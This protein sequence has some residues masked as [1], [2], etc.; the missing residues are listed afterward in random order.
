MKK[1]S[2]I[3]LGIVIVVVAVIILISVSNNQEQ[4]YQGT[5]IGVLLPLSGDFA[6]FGE[7]FKRGIEDASSS[8]V[9]LIFEDTVCQNNPTISGFRKLTDVDGVKYIIGPACSSPQ[10]AIAPLVKEK[11]IL[12]ILPLAASEDLYDKSGGKIYQMQYSL[13]D[14]ASYLA[15]TLAEKGYEKVTL[16]GYQN[17]LSETHRNSFK[18]NFNGEIQEIVFADTSSNINTEL[19]KIASFEPDAIFVTDISFFVINGIEKVR[20]FNIE[21]PIFSQYATQYDPIR[22]FVEGVTYSFPGDIDINEGSEYSLAKQATELLNSLIEECSAEFTCVK[23][24]LEA[25]DLFNEKGIST[26][27][28]ILKK[29]VEGQPTEVE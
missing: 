26:R 25:S 12:V 5:K 18:A 21:A 7:S 28:I 4:E 15:Q 10:E 23:D 22:D 17:A 8:N 9:N 1:G 20:Q 27:P 19:L 29:I 14:E 6:S 2:K 16:I 13:Q 3:W 11:D 24:K